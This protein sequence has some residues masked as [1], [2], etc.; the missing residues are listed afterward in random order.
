MKKVLSLLVAIALIFSFS[1]CS[2]QET[3]PKEKTN[4][5]VGAIKGPT[6]VGFAN[7]MESNANGKANNNYE[8]TLFTSPEE[9]GAKVVK[10]E[11]NIAALPTN[12]AAN[13]YQKTNG[14]VQ[15]LAINTL[16]NMSIIEKGETINSVKDLKGKTVYSIGQGANP[17]YILKYILSKNGIED[18]VKIKFVSTNDEITA[19]L[20]TGKA[21][22]AMIAE[23]AATAALIKNTDCSR[24]L[25]INEVWNDIDSN[26]PV[27]TGCVVANAEFVKNNPEAVK[28]FLDEYEDSINSLE[29][30]EESANLTVKHEILAAVPVAKQSI[31]NSNIKFIKSEDMKTSINAY[32]NVLYGFNPASVGGKM[33]DDNFFYVG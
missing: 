28:L 6:G 17:E 9:I 33:P 12:V 23:P 31:P 2:K 21:T 27:V 29:N 7:L 24:R 19:A 25:D 32:F 30:L 5:T 4:V 20:A 15:M 11:L 26:V 10:N 14:K 1:A 22:V 8:F 16:G 13:L 18:S 3:T